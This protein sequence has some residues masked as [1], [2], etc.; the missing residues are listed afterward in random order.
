MICH[1]GHRHGSVPTLLWLWDRLAAA[2]LISPLAWELPNIR[3]CAPKKSQK[4]F[5]WTIKK[6]WYLWIHSYNKIKL[7][8]FKIKLSYQRGNYWGGRINWE[9]GINAVHTTYKIDN[10]DLL[11]Y[12]REVYSMFSNNIQGKKE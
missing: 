10:K 7:A 4:K 1:V 11:I 5:L 2:A 3:G 6:K 12:H 9:N 8:D